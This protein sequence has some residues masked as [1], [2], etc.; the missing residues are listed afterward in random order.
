MVP[1]ATTWRQPTPCVFP[2]LPLLMLSPLVSFLVATL[3]REEEPLG[4]WLAP[5]CWDL[6]PSVE[7]PFDRTR[8]LLP[9]VFPRVRLQIRCGRV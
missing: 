6:A 4:D 9:W 8:A 5:V 3:Q 2:A 1:Q 7:H